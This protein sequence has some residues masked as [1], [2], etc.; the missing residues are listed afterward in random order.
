MKISVF[1][2]KPFSQLIKEGFQKLGHEIS[3]ENLDL[4]YSNDP[5]G[6]EES[7]ILKKK[8]PKAI[9]VFNVLDIPWHMPNIENQTKL[10]IKHFLSKADFI[11]VISFKV[12]SD[13]AKFTNIKTKVIY[14]PIKDVNHENNI[15]KDN[16]FLFVGRAND[17]VKR[18]KLVHDSL[19]KIDNGLNNLN[20]CGEHD[21]GFGNYLGY[22][23]DKRLNELYNSSKYVFLTSIAEG[24]GLPMIEAMVCGSIPILCS[25]NKTS[26]EFSPDDFICEPD[27][28]SIVQKINYIN[29]NYSEKRELALKLGK[30][31][32]EKFDKVSIAKNILKVIK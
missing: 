31:Y 5:R 8:N 6:Y 21:P 9:I 4:I 25:D 11:T 2:L 14:N 19:L 13:L 24:I 17:P 12:Q 15:T 22:V 23:T 10:L 16:S 26:K 32:K 18:I 27:V 20:I 1:G 28:S 3:S 7:L 29:K 30:K